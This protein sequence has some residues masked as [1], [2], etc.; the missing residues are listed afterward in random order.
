MGLVFPWGVVGDLPWG[1]RGGLKLPI[2]MR[3]LCFL[4][5]RLKWWCL[6]PWARFRI[7]FTIK[8]WYCAW[9]RD[10]DTLN[11]KKWC[12]SRDKVDDVPRKW[13]CSPRGGNVILGETLGADVTSAPKKKAPTPPPSVYFHYHWA[14]EVNTARTATWM[15]KPQWWHHIGRESECTCAGIKSTQLMEGKRPIPPPQK[16]IHQWII[17]FQMSTGQHK[18]RTHLLGKLLP[19]NLLDNN[20]S[21]WPTFLFS[22]FFI[23]FSVAIYHAHVFLL[24]F[25]YL[26]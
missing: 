2:D 5:K 22:L 25:K 1:M 11:G 10:V 12:Y 13:W 20:P 9:G 16:Q 3:M 26:A 21:T 15:S 19:P 23:Y 14:T 17:R 6:V 24:T 7:I 8:R 18:T 4:W